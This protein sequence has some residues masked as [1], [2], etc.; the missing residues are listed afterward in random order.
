MNREEL[1]PLFG[2]LT[3][4]GLILLLAIAGDHIIV[5]LGRQARSGAGDIGSITMLTMWVR[6]A[7]ILLVS[8]ASLLAMWII[9]ISERSRNGEQRWQV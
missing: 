2:A 5:Y 7:T 8:I 3:G 1:F 6:S 9:K 4:L